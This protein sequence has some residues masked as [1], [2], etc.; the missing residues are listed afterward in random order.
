MNTLPPAHEVQQAM[1]VGKQTL[2]GKP[3]DIL[4]IEVPIDPRH[5]LTGGLLDHLNRTMCAR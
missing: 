4:A 1:C 3:A 2:V 5:A